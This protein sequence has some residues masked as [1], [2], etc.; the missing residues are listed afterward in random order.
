MYWE[1]GI[2]S[3]RLNAWGRFEPWILDENPLG[4]YASPELA[5]GDLCH[6]YP[7]LKLPD[8]LGEWTRK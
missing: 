8:D 4:N 1:Y 5:L 2:C 3:I 6:Y 7:D